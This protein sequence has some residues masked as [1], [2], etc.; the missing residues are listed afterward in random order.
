MLQLCLLLGGRADSEKLRD[1]ARKELR[2]YQPGDEIPA[3]RTV[4]AIIAIDGQVGPN[5]I[6]NE[7]I[8]SAALPEFAREHISELVEL[9]DGIGDIEQMANVDRDSLRLMLPGSAELMTIM[10]AQMRNSG[11]C[12]TRIFWLTSRASMRGV[13]EQVRTSL[14]ELVSEITALMP[15][16]QSQPSKE[17]V[18]QAVDLVVTGK[19]HNVTIVSSQAVHAPTSSVALPSA[20]AET[21]WQR[22]RKRGLIIGLSTV[23]AAAA[24][25]ATWLE[26]TPWK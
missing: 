15:N 2:G 18:D 25:V 20:S 1:W 7:Q 14:V 16:D 5:Q 26:W 21:W 19:R 12:I 10:N 8:S 4:P 11:R 17:A 23:V 3:Y 6:R 22:W 13:V 24:A 9:R